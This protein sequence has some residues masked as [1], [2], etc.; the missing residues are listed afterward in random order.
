MTRPQA[1][2]LSYTLYKRR[3]AANVVNKQSRMLDRRLSPSWV[4]GRGVNSYSPFIIISMLH[5]ASDFGGF[6]GGFCVRN[7]TICRICVDDMH[8]L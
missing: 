8:L 7:C 1:A 3:L 4:V 2:G 5:R 6:L